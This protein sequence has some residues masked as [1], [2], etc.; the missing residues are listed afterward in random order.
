MPAPRE[1][2]R[3]FTIHG[4]GPCRVARRCD[5]NHG[6]VRDL[7]SRMGPK[8]DEFVTAVVVPMSETCPPLPMA[9]PVAFRPAP[10][11]ADTPGPSEFDGLNAL[12]GG[13]RRRVTGAREEAQVTACAECYEARIPVVA[14]GAG[15][16]LSG[17]RRPA[18]GGGIVAVVA[19]LMCG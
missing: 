7:S 19:K 3:G 18:S 12:P 11:H 16:S 8:C 1:S 9:R 14:R 5:I 15:N 17:C 6:E 4:V 10:G 2:A 13:A